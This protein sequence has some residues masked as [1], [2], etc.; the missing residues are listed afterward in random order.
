M[1]QST[2]ATKRQ[3]RL[4]ELTTA[5]THVVF[6]GSWSHNLDGELGHGCVPIKFYL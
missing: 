4:S 2:G 6:S 3:T 1:L 5:T